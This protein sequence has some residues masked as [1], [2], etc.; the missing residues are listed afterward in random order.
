MLRV[1]DE[2][3]QQ[4]PARSG[5]VAESFSIAVKSVRTVSGLTVGFSGILRGGVMD[6]KSLAAGTG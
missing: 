1:G 6:T 3:S 4:T 5:P 2:T